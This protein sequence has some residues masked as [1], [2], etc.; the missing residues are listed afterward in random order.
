MSHGSFALMMKCPVIRDQW[1]ALITY[2]HLSNIKYFLAKFNN[3]ILW[4]CLF[5]IT[6][7]LFCKQVILDK[8]VSI[9]FVMLVFLLCWC[10]SVFLLVIKKGL[11]HNLCFLEKLRSNHGI[12]YFLFLRKYFIVIL[13]MMKEICLSANLCTKT[14]IVTLFNFLF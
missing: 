10:F 7:I 1:F 6:F 14:S 8:F 12:N 2:D 9:L 4:Y 11:H 3:W 5:I 13:I